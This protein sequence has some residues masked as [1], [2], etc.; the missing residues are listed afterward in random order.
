MRGIRSAAFAATIAMLV[1][2]IAAGCGSSG[3]GTGSGGAG[4]GNQLSA[5]TAAYMKSAMPK[6]EKAL[7]QWSDG[8]QS[9]AVKTWKSIGDIPTTNAADQVMADDYLKY[10]NN[11]RY[12][13]IGDGSATLKDVEDAQTTAVATW[14]A[15]K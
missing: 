14:S 13:F 3:S 7:S 11:V 6:L 15:F 10:A 2:V 5:E 8:N 9:A 1:L 4:D 12:Y